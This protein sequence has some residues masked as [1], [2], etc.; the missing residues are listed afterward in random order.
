LHRI[1]SMCTYGGG[2]KKQMPM[3]FFDGK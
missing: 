2:R 1:S 3:S